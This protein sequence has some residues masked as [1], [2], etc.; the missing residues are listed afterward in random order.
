M[1]LNQ[2]LENTTKRLD[3]VCDKLDCIELTGETTLI[4]NLEF[5]AQNGDIIDLSSLPDKGIGGYRLTSDGDGTISWVAGAGSSGVD[6]NGTDPV[7][8]GKIAIYGATNGKLIKESTLSDTDILNKNGDT[9][10]GN[11]D[12]GSNDIDSVGNIEATTLDGLQ[13]ISGTNT[14]DLV[15]NNAGF[16]IKIPS[17][18][19]DLNNNSIE[20]VFRLN[21]G[22]IKNPSLANIDIEND[23]FLRD[24]NITKVANINV[25]TFS[26]NTLPAILFNDDVSLFNND[27]VSAGDIKTTSF[28]STDSKT[29]DIDVDANLDLQTTRNI[30]NVNNIQTQQIKATDGVSLNFEDDINMGQYEINNCNELKVS[31]ISSAITSDINILS[32]LDMNSNDISGVGNLEVVSVNNLTPVGGLY[33]GISDGVVINQASGTADLLPTTSVGSLSIPVNG[34]KVG[35]AYHLVIAGIF[36]DEAKG[37]DVEIEIKQNGTVIGSVTLDYED[38]DTVE[39]NFELEADFVIRSVGATGSLA[40]NI[41]FTFNK[42]VSKDFKGTRSTTITTIDTTT[43]SSLTV[44]ATVT[45]ANSS[46]QSRLAYLRKQ[47]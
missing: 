17:C 46:I 9:M 7:A 42:K 40:S 45:G 4:D 16:N 22:R 35:D 30:K 37:D 8:I 41:D 14:Q 19:L 32:I 1:S 23:L 25:D 26:V 3:I 28:S 21:V 33:C 2:I 39:S 24:N 11:L 47:Y 44:T 18:N 10:A 31:S 5:K 36:P 38:F 43:A 29:N 34:F 6:Y 13:A 12:M 15:L 20:N 27:I